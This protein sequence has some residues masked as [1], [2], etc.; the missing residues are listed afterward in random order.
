M[1]QTASSFRDPD[2]VCIIRNGRV[3]RFVRSHAVEDVRNLI[4]A[5]HFSQWVAHGWVASTREIGTE[6]AVA[7]F[8]HDIQ[9]WTPGMVLEQ[10]R[11]PFVSYA[12]EWC[13]EMLYSAA[14]LTLDLQ[15]SALSH[16]LMLKDATPSNVLFRGIKPVFVDV[17]SFVRRPKGMGIWPAYAQFVR[18]FILPLLMH[19]KHG[20]GIH[21]VFL[22][23]RD[24][25]EPEA[26]YARL[27]WIE[28][29]LPAG[30]RYASLPTW[31]G[32][33]KAAQESAPANMKLA[34]E[35]RARE[36]APMLVEALR[37]SL[38]SVRPSPRR[39]VWTDY[40]ATSTYDL[41]STQVKERFVR[42]ILGKWRPRTVLDVGSNTGHYAAVAAASGASVVA[43]DYDSEVVDAIFRRTFGDKGDVLPL[44]VNMARPTPS[45]GWNCAETSAFLKR[46]CGEFDAALLLAVIHHLTVTDGVPI[47]AIFRLLAAVVKMGA[48]VEYVPPDDP[49][50]RRIVR[51]KEHLIP[52]L[53]K[54]AYEQAFSTWFVETDR[55]PVP[56]SGRVLY[57]LRVR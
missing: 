20:G 15:L 7:E 10:E 48:I 29:I 6:Q 13:P 32:S 9:D 24:G 33:S 2:G 27:S 25:L 35:E 4:H 41:D 21:E 16:G 22:C 17:L 40:T 3:L 50:F 55:L 56:H 46:V 38:R 44:V 51:N 57:A 34:S 49:Q 1:I 36:L 19:K 11:I 18:T 47:I 28:R 23:H 26:A 39:S 30:L 52:L 43:I 5:P 14:E 37:R 54:A 53:G 31:L 42:E 12:H 45:L 8:G